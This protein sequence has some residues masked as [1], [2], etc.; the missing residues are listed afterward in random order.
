MN[1]WSHRV[2]PWLLFSNQ[3]SWR[4]NPLTT[5]VLTSFRLEKRGD[6]PSAFNSQFAIGTRSQ[7][8]P[9]QP[10]SLETATPFSFDIPGV[11]FIHP[12]EYAFVM[13]YKNQQLARTRF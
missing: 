8:R 5:Q 1:H 10:D 12:G 2:I 4:T 9:N 7:A 3:S 11:F 13:D 6:E